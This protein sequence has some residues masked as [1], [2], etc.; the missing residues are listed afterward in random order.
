MKSIGELQ[1][2]HLGID[3][4]VP[5]SVGRATTNTQVWFNVL[6]HITAIYYRT[7]HG[8]VYYRLER[9]KMSSGNAPT[10]GLG[11]D[12]DDGALGHYLVKSGKI[13][14]LQ[15]PVVT[16]KIG[17]GQSNPTYFVDDAT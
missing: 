8:S 10:P 15:S 7:P 17:Y 14:D 11:H 12:L 2:V 13:P 16:T 6:I 4:T 5:R 3:H 9:P 1:V